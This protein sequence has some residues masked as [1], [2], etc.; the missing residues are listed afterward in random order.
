[1]KKKNVGKINKID[2]QMTVIY[3]ANIRVYY[4]S[5]VC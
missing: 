2:C 1:M 3:T 4:I 5:V